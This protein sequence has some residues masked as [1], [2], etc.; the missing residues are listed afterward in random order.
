MVTAATVLLPKTRCA[1]R[2]TPAAGASGTI[3]SPS[4]DD[5]HEPSGSQRSISSKAVRTNRVE[6]E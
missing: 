4:C 1:T 2:A 6:S 5:V 3:P